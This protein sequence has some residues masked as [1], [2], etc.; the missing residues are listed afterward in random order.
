MR[1]SAFVYFGVVWSRVCMGTSMKI[2]I[3]KNVRARH[4]TAYFPRVK[5]MK[6][7]LKLANTYGGYCKLQ[8][9]GHSDSV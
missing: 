3:F 1:F 6:F 9:T 8:W 5:I 2:S 7:G 4:H